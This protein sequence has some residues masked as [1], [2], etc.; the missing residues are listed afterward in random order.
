MVT[1]V[2]SLGRNGV[3]DWLVQRI[4]AVLLATYTLVLVGYL[5]SLPEVTYR[6][7]TGLFSHTWMQVFTLVTL[8]ATCAHAWIGM[9]TLGTDYL[10]VR[11][12]GKNANTMRF[13]YQL[14]CML[15][16]VTYLL[17]GVKILWG[18]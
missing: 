15:V 6:Q 5:A 17:W 13:I 2:T 9:W 11:T 16:L 14:G 3:S 8:L 12:T 7:W 10:R 1:Q 18:N 4:T